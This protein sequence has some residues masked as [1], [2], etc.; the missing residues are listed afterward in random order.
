MRA[1]VSSPEGL[2]LHDVAVPEPG[3]EQLLVKVAA[4][5]M[6]RADLNAARGAGVARPEDMGRP[7]GMEWAGEVV[8]LGTDV[9]GFALGDLV[10]CSG[11]GGYAEFAVCDAGRA[12]RITP[13]TLDLQAAAAL[14]L[15]L[16]TAHNALALGAFAP[17]SN[18]FVHGASSAVGIAAIQIAR[19][20]G[21]GR[22]GASARNPAKR[23]RLTGYGA[24]MVFAPGP[25][26]AAEWLNACGGADVLVDMIAGPAFD[27]TLSAMA[28]LGRLVLVGRLG[29]TR[30]EFDLDR[31]MLKRL[32]VVG[33][34]FRTRSIGEVRAIVEGV[35]RDVWPHVLGGRLTL[36]VDHIFPLAEAAQAHALMAGDGHF[37]KI[38]LVP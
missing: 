26:W 8:A 22:I 25:G 4:A 3:A 19:L 11:T 24:D 13:G 34:T 16:M 10:A 37:G 35:R 18:V 27:E 14:P 32:S 29:G 12:I 36:P 31:I 20:H 30:A 23:D 17:G 33:A 5:G 28:L 7:I 1:A 9:A 21:A 2:V 6:N 15:V 38:V